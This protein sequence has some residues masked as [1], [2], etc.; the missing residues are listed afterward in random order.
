MT[1]D[2]RPD[3][4]GS[5]LARVAEIWAGLAGADPE[6]LAANTRS[7]YTPVVGDSGELRLPVWGRE[8]LVA[9]PRFAATWADDAA[10]VDP[11]TTALLAYYFETCDGTPEAGRRIA[12]SELRDG[13]FYAQ[14]FQGYT[15]NE[16]AKAFGN[17]TG[18]FTDAA[19]D[20]GGL[21]ETLADR[22]FS[23]RVLPLV[24][25]AVACWLGDED[26]GPS[27]RVLFDAAVG[28][29][30]PT[31]VC[32]IVGGVLTRRLIAAHGRRPGAG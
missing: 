24:S 3:A 15:G 19:G 17:D 22:A 7:S 28:H 13:S 6:R 26:S 23:F 20:L 31:G 2:D 1:D 18:T 16:L 10:T 30:L 9:F 32:A 5:L 8:A 29:H 14:A 21:P 4:T 11:F 27:Y 25:V 12:F